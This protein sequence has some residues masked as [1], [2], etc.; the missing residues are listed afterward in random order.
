[1]LKRKLLITFWFITAS[2][3]LI[4]ADATLAPPAVTQGSDLS[5]NG[6]VFPLRIINQECWAGLNWKFIINGTFYDNGNIIKSIKLVDGLGSTIKTS[7]TNFTYS[8][9]T[10]Q[11]STQYLTRKVDVG[12]TPSGI[13][14]Y[15]PGGCNGLFLWK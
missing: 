4:A 9:P 3:S 2:S 13:H 15:T 6:P 5:I 7:S 12:G 14:V 1:M 11:G 10:F 8:I